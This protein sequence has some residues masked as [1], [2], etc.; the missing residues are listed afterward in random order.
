METPYWLTDAE[1]ALPARQLDGPPEV[2]I[3]GAGI[4]GCACA[5][6][7]ARA[8]RRVRVLDERPHVAEGASGRNGGFALGGGAARYDVARQSYGHERALLLWRRTEDALGRLGELAGDALR[9][10]GSL[11][12]AADEEERD[13]I[14]KEF[15]ALREDSLDA[16]WRDRGDL[17][18]H[19]RGSF[20][21]AIFHPGD[22]AVHP[23]RLV[24][25]LAAAAAEEGAEFPLGKRLERLDGREGA[26]IVLA[27]DGYGRGLVPEVDER[28]WPARGQ[29]VA[30]EPL[31]ERLFPIPHYARQ[32][33]DYWQQLEDGRL[34]AGG[35]RDFSIMSELTDVEET[36]PVIQDALTSFIHELLGREPEITHRWA[37][38]FGLTQDLPPLVGRVPGYDGVWVAAGYSGHGNVLGFLSGGL[39]A[40]GLLGKDDPLLGLFDPARLF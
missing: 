25:R 37:G 8:G 16:E 31:E 7:L 33:F 4:T 21:G 13:D 19:L 39:V 20:H 23:A 24:R 34:V 10:E 17:P 5:L 6:A 27:T 1:I 26:Q 12:L 30:T 29:V 38:I 2:E 36:T 40:R 3:V 18:E 22:G 35:F 14:R 11:R 15:E 28:I 9:R 32:G